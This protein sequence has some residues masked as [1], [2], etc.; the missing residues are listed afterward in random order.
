MKNRKNKITSLL[1]IAI[2]LFGISLLLW[3]C[4]DESIQEINQNVAVEQVNEFQS[5]ET[6]EAKSLIN[7]IISKNKKQL[8]KGGFS[9]TIDENSLNYRDVKKTNLTIPTF[10]ASV[11][12]NINSTVFLV[13]KQDSI[14]ACLYNYIPFE[15]KNSNPDVL[16]GKIIISTI[17]GEFIN[18]YKVINGVFISQY[19]QKIKN[20]IGSKTFRKDAEPDEYWWDLGSLDEVVITTTGG[21]SLYFDN[22]YDPVSSQGWMNLNLSGSNTSGGGGSSSGSG[23]NTNNDG[24][25]LFNCDN[26]TPTGCIECPNGEVINGICVDDDQIFNE[27]TGKDLCI[28]NE[29]KKLDLFKSTIN[30]FSKGKYNLTFK[31]G[32]ICNNQA[33]EEACTDPKDLANGNLTIKILSSGTQS[34]DFAATLLH[35]GIHAEIYKYVDEHKKGID[36]NDRKNLFYYYNYYSAQNNNRRETSLAQHQHMQDVFVTPIA[37]AIR[38]LDGYRHNIDYYKGF[39]FEGIIKKYGYDKYLDNGVVKTMTPD[40][41]K[42]YENKMYNVLSTT[43]FKDALKNCN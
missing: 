36:P 39:A 28:F 13:K 18:G 17:D 6:N 14:Y 20:K 37:R 21:G 40:I 41:Y 29:L 25:P 8:R 38:Q 16:S 22:N 10:S 1:K 27:L 32:T 34:L 2:L 43:K 5:I 12:P 23:G 26:P 35:E 7:S 11:K 19:K 4:N 33:G 31:Y 24:V 30:K 42:S 9:L 15:D 3:N